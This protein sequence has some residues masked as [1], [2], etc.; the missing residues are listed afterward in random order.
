MDLT[1]SHMI[2]PIISAS[3]QRG[4]PHGVVSGMIGIWGEAG[5]LLVMGTVN[6]CVSLWKGEIPHSRNF[7]RKCGLVLLRM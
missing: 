6:R 1:L 3:I 4:G 7:E 2:R 5:A